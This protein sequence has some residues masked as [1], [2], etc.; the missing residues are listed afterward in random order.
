VIEL[1]DLSLKAARLAD[2]APPAPPPTAAPAV[3]AAPAAAPAPAVPVQ[4][5]HDDLPSN[6]PEYLAKVERDIII[7]ALER[8]QFNRTQ[9]AQLLG[10]SFR[11]LRYQMQKL[12]I[13]DPDN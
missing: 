10:I 1:C 4:G 6:L 13:Q 9:A 5:E 8:T 11:Q 12:D 3:P 2:M 7:R